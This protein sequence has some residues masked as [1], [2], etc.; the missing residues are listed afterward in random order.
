MS[1][2]KIIRCCVTG[3]GRWYTEATSLGPARNP[4]RSQMGGQWADHQL[5]RWIDQRPW[6]M[7]KGRRSMGNSIYQ[8]R[9]DY[10]RQY[11]MSNSTVDIDET[12]R[13]D[14]LSQ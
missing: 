13:S 5:Q 11:R 6:T 9:C 14:L 2:R 12:C 10:G 7:E 1:R 4:S 3:G 8:L